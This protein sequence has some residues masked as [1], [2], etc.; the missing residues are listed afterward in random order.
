M[1]STVATE[2]VNRLAVYFF[3]AL[4]VGTLQGILKPAYGQW[5]KHIIDDNIVSAVDVDVGDLDGDTKLDL[6]VTDWSGNELIWY[7]NDFPDWIRHTID[8]YANEVTF[9]SISD[10]D[11]DGTLDVVASL[12]G[13]MEM[14]WYEN[15]H[16]TWT[17]NYI[18]L[19]TDHADFMLVADFD[20][21][22]TPDVVTAG[23]WDVGGDVVWY[24][25]NHPD[26]PWIEHIIESS[27]DLHPALNVNDIDGDGLLDVSVTMM[28]E[29]KIVWFRNE[30]NGLS[31]TKY[32]IDDD[33]FCAFGINS[34]DIDGDG[35]IDIVA[36]SMNGNDVY[37][38]ENHHPT[39]IKH[40]ID[41]DCHKPRVF[42]VTDIDEDGFID[43]IVAATG[44][45]VWYE[46]PTVGVE[47]VTSG[48]PPEF[49]L[50]QNDPNPFNSV[51]TIEYTLPLSGD[52]SLIIYNIVG[53]EM[54]RLIDSSLNAGFHQVTWD[55]SNF[56]SGIYFY[57][58]Q[59]GD[60]FQTRKMV[61]LK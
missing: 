1:K 48:I 11:G 42:A 33:L 50:Y 21:D 40:T 17:K 22:D 5:Q 31:W 20:G 26:W 18:D 54:A 58:L 46:N 10:I 15:N 24:E 23:G 30:N 7:Q 53:Q 8:G 52:V 60:F 32:T 59:T 14:V 3:V 13:P 49:E 47:D 19:V 29:N 16:P 56:A 35:T 39:W 43:V 38:Y 55:A 44:Y 4:T 25:N 45:V 9:A 61:F 28:A 57:R 2:K 41:A 36:T 34:G 51:T 6:V 37:W 27:S 12:F